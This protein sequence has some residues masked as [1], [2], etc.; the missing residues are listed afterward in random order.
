MSRIVFSRVVE[1]A[2]KANDDL[3]LPLDEL[4]G[5]APA[6]RGLYL[7]VGRA[8]ERA[9]V[10]E[11]ELDALSLAL[12]HESA[13]GSGHQRLFRPACQHLEVR[14]GMRNLHRAKRYCTVGQLAK[15]LIR[16]ESPLARVTGVSSSRQ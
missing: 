10:A 6:F 4:V 11:V 8:H 12:I 5:A 16:I 1:R 7:V 15:S 9:A 3:R 13:H 14:G 2:F